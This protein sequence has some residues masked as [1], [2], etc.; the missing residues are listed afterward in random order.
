MSDRKMGHVQPFGTYVKV[1]ASLLFLTVVTVWVARFDFGIM[2][3]M[4]AV[5]VA[6][7]K[8]SL[9]TLFFMHGKYEGKITWAFVYYPVLLLI[10]LLGALFLDYGY[11]DDEKRHIQEPVIA[12][13]QHHDQGSDQTGN[14]PETPK[15]KPDN[16]NH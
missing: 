2:N 10:L 13:E 4:V 11:R 14:H 12:Q 9:V 8:A 1:F 5:G 15:E 3:N 16:G 7:I 6:T